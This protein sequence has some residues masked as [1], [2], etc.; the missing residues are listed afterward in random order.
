MRVEELDLKSVDH[1]LTTTRAVRRRLDLERPVPIDVIREC[2]EIAVQAP[3][4][5]NLQNWRWLVVTDSEKRAAI[6][7]VYRRMLTPFLELMGEASDSEDETTARIVKSCRHLADNLHRA[8]VHVIP[9]TT[10][11]V[12]DDESVFGRLG[13]ET[14]LVNMSASG[15]FGEVWTAGWSF[16][17]ALRARGLGSSMTTIHLGGEDE[18][19]R[20]LGIPEGV[21][22]AGLIPV[23]WFTG[24]D[25]KP[26][27][28]RRADEITFYDRW[29][30]TSPDG[31]LG[32]DNASASRPGI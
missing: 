16:M 21:S 5:F 28:R 13:F 24:D 31:L 32:Y 12:K 15:V 26:A 3:T 14:D 11:Q 17:L 9:C 29:E 25:F 6:A 1:V 7:E 19:A 23:A 18:V 8:P 30:Q 20:L 22:Q 10:L 4:G 27:N 2:L